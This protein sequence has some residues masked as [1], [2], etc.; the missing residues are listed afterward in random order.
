MLNKLNEMVKTVKGCLG[1]DSMIDIVDTIDEMQYQIDT[2]QL[3]NTE[4]IAY[5]ELQNVLYDYYKGM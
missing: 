4:M 1:N 2:E 5:N 3:S